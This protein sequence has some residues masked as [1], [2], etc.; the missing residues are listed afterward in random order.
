VVGN[1]QLTKVGNPLQS[2]YKSRYKGVTRQGRR[3]KAEG[4]K[5][6]EKA[7]NLGADYDYELT[8]VPL[9]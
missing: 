3:K 9:L 6:A 4:R 1:E 5:G 7:L 8:L 2:R